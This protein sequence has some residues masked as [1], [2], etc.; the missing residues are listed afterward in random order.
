MLDYLIEDNNLLTVF[1]EYGLDEQDIT[2]VKEQVAGPN[3]EFSQ[4]H[5]GDHE[6]VII[7]R[8][9]FLAHLSQRLKVNCCDRSSSV[10]HCSSSIN[11]SLNDIS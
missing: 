9:L 3:K 11:F 6:K 1:N 7:L 8:T 5:T 2:F 10:A 4:H